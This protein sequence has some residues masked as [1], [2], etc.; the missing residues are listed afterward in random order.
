MVDGIC[1]P[2][3]AN[4]LQQVFNHKCGYPPNNKIHIPPRMV[5][6][7]TTCII[8][9]TRMQGKDFGWRYSRVVC[10]DDDNEVNVLLRRDLKR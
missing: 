5:I 2:F 10:V 1:R 7:K 9:N 6:I 3:D 4:T 8:I